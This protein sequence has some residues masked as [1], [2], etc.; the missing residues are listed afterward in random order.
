[1]ISL[2]A[3]ALARGASLWCSHQGNW[4][5]ARPSIVQSVLA[6]VPMAFDS[7]ADYYGA[8]ALMSMLIDAGDEWPPQACDVFAVALTSNTSAQHIAVWAGEYCLAEAKAKA[9]A[10]A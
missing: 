5:T 8:Q 10:Q 3:G 7:H 4:P 1:M 9:K 6:Q 2:E